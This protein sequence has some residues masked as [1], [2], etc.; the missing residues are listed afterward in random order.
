MAEGDAGALRVLYLGTVVTEKGIE[1]FLDAALRLLDRSEN[2]EFAV[3]G[4]WYRH[5]ERQRLEAK[6]RVHQRGSRISFVGEVT[7]NQKAEQLYSSDI[8]VFPGTQQEGLP[9]VVLEAMC[10]GMPVVASNVGCLQ[11]VI[12]EG[13]TGFLVPP[14]DVASLADRLQRLADD[15]ALYRQL[16]AA[17]R[18][19]YEKCYRQEIF[20][21]RMTALF[22]MVV[23]GNDG[24]LV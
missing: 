12:E 9:L 20:E 2:W 21:E 19:R 17:G 5:E 4:P 22:Q 1:I 24:K 15:R 6:A 13:V 11:E 10:A 3:A 8:F 7:G 23:T 18:R 14:G 16:G